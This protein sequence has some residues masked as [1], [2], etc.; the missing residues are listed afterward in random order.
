[1][2]TEFK[3]FTTSPPPHDYRK[4]PTLYYADDM[5]RQVALHFLCD[6]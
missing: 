3:S 2:T 4:K 5:D 1:M 6:L